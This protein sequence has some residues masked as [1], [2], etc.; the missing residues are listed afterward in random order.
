MRLNRSQQAQHR[1]EQIKPPKKYGW[2]EDEVHFAPITNSG[3]PTT[4]QEAMKN[5]E[6]EGWMGVSYDG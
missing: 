3:D 2:D 5:S 4:F 6:R 1:V